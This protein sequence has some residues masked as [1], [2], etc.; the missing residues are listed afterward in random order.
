MDTNNYLTDCATHD[1][2]KLVFHML[3]VRSRCKLGVNMQGECYHLAAPC[4][5]NSRTSD[6]VRFRIL[7]A[8]VREIIGTDSFSDEIIVAAR[9]SNRTNQIH[10]IQKGKSRS[11]LAILLCGGYGNIIC[12]TVYKKRK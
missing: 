11:S 7:R 10:P 9:K 1:Y 3:T 2:A 8:R 6:R 12:V 5:H 4:T